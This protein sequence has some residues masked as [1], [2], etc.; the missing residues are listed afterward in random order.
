M[1]TGPSRW[2]QRSPVCISMAPP[3]FAP[4]GAQQNYTKLGDESPADHAIGKSRGGKTCKIH[5]ATY[6]KGRRWDSSS[7]LASPP[8]PHSSKPFWRPAR[9]P[10]APRDGPQSAH[11]IAG[12][13]RCGSKG[14][15]TPSTLH[16]DAYKCVGDGR[17]VEHCS[18]GSNNWRGIATRSDK[19]APS[20]LAGITLASAL[21]W[22]NSGL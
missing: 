11:Q 2:T 19:T 4:Q 12:R 20:Y 22:I 3:S 10:A 16:K 5:L 6:S 9:S 1:S 13:A 15:W 17:N 8:T 7:P 21:I 14:G 18:N